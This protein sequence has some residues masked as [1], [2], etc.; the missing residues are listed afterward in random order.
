M[1]EM[2]GLFI[3]LLR[4]SEQYT[5]TDMLYFARGTSW[6][7]IGQI[8]TTLST[9][10]LAV[11]VGHFIPKDIYGVYKFVLSI[12]TVLAALSLNGLGKAVFQSV[13]HG[14]E[15]ALQ[16]N[17]W[18]N[19]RW[20]A[21]VLLGAFG[22]SAYYYMHGNTEIALGILLGGCASPLIASGNL[23]NSF[24]AAKKDFA[25][26]TIYFGIIETIVST[27]VLLLVVIFTKNALAITAAYFIGN[28]LPTLYLYYR[29]IQVYRP[30]PHAVDPGT[31]TYGK[32]LSAMGILS[33]IADNIDQILLFHFFGAAELAVYTFATAIPD[34]AKGP[35]K[36]LDNMMQAQF[37]ARTDAEIRHGMFNKTMWLFIAAVIA[38]SAYILATPYIF[39]IFFPRYVDA[40]F[41]SQLYALMYLADIFD[42]AASYLVVKKKLRAQYFSTAFLSLF[43]IAAVA[44][45][46]IGWGLIGVI[47]ARIVT[48]FASMLFASAQF[49]YISA[50][51]QPRDAS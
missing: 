11:A 48:R 9:F 8:V 36:N 1:T 7:L 16:T 50:P 10:A 41:F 33:V 47:I 3:R 34:Q 17:F 6:A 31:L 45:G 18:T 27:A 12:V 22:V 43:R 21:A 19:L 4:W 38:I 40:I 42:P 32:H 2:K 51:K 39:H 15:G 20:S 29:V 23:A 44:V 14:Y 37:A 26:S 24:L 35:L 13:A 5:K 25:R 46:A 49:W 30:D 28:A